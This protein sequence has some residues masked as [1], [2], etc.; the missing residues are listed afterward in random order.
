MAFK[1]FKIYMGIDGILRSSWVGLKYFVE[2]FTD[3]MFWTIFRNTIA[4]SFLKL[5][6]TFPI[7]II[8]AI[9]LNEVKTLHF[10]KIVQ[11]VSYLPHFVSWVVVSGLVFTFL[12]VDGGVINIILTNLGIIREPIPFLIEEKNFWGLVVVTDAWKEFGWWSIL[13]IAAIAGIDVSLYE[14]AIIDGAGRLARIWH[15]TLPGIRGAITVVLILSL[16]NLLGGGISG[17]NFEQCL[18]MGNALNSDYSEI[19]QT[20]VLKIGL[21]QGRFSYATAVNLVQSVIAAFLIFSSNRIARKLSGM[22]LF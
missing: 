14:A 17:S 19:I 4:I 18:L 7:P 6:F 3:S 1:D 11:T 8:F 21:G 15:I 13:F 2:F 9:M 16:G 12:S 22:S 10:K 20:Y 5:I